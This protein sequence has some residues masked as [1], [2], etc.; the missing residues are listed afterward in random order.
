MSATSQKILT[1][2]DE[3]M[4]RETIVSYLENRGFEVFQ[5]QN[6]REGLE[7]FTAVKPDLL[8]VDLRM[9]EMDGLE[10]LA[11]VKE[12]APETPSIVV[13]GTGILKDAVEAIKCGAWDYVIKPIQDMDILGLAVDKALERARLIRENKAYQEN[14]E[15]LVLERTVEV[16]RT[17]RQIMQRLSRTAEFKDNETGRHV[18]RVG[19]I[20]ALLGKAMGFDQAQCEMLRECAPLHDI[21]KIGIPDAILLKP[22]RLTPSEWDIMKR[23]CVYGCEILGPLTSLEE[24]YALCSDPFAKKIEDNKLLH[25]ARTLAL[26]H[27]ERW[28]GRGYPFGLSGEDIPLEARIVTV[29]DVFDALSSTRSYKEAFSEEQCLEILRQ[30]AGSQFDP[31][32]IEAFFEHKDEIRAI[33]EAWK[34]T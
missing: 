13:S 4:I 15:A 7:V 2:D 3:E 19:E 25:L 5:A 28:D 1:V 9:P 14:L 32:V 11:R 10:V 24:A 6:G 22:D 8:L 31:R 21:G 26:L 29:V 20:S 16:E 33:R 12:L 34:D 23:H 17:R 18:V 30:G 27:H